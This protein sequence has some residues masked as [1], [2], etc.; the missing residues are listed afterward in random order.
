MDS[1]STKRIF[2]SATNGTLG[3]HLTTLFLYLPK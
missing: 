2:E 3:K 1:N